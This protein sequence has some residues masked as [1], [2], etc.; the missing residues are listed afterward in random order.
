MFSSTKN[1]NEGT[2]AKTALL[3]NHPSIS[4]R[5]VTN[6]GALKEEKASCRETVVQNAKV[7]STTFPMSSK[8]FR[9]SNSK[10]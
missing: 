2:F 3:Q 1:P 8:V 9:C 4:S 7:D 6:G 10:P 5:C